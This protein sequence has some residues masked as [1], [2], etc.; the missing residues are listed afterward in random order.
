LFRGDELILCETE[1]DIYAALGMD[2]IPPEL[3]EDTGE[4]DAAQA[5]RLPALIDEKMIRGVFH[6][7]TTESDGRDTLE[8]MVRAAEA[9]GYGYVGIS[10]HS[11]SA[12]YANGLSIER[13]AAQH[14]AIDQLQRRH[15]GIVIFKGIESDILADGSLDY[16]D[17]VL[18][19]FDFV[20]ASI[21][22]RF[23]M[24][25]REMTDRIVRAISHPAV[26]ILG[27]PTGRLL[28][29]RDGYHLDMGAVLDTAARY[30]VAVELNANPHRLDLDWRVCKDARDRGVKISINPDAHSADGLADTRLGVGIGRKG[31]LTRDDLFNA[32]GAD[33]MRQTLA[34]RRA[35]APSHS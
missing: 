15:P 10:D 19:R 7:H 33:E 24:S 2:E 16:P 8:A 17:E 3:R 18:A 25:E 22:S 14:A 6:V 21:H 1:A 30:G 9:L 12:H 11:R 32:Q 35:A 29:S 20:I 23:G 31:W 34:A 28:L 4:I 27:H 26:T 5:H 13:V